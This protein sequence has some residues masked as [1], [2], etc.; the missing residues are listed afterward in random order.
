MDRAGRR[1]LLMIAGF[2]MAATTFMMS[3]YYY[4]LAHDAEY[5][6]SFMS[7]AV[8]SL[9]LYIVGYSLGWGPVPGLVMSE[10]FPI[11][12]RASASA[13]TTIV[14]WGS[15]FLMTKIFSDFDSPTQLSHA[16][17]IFGLALIMSVI[18]VSKLVPETKGKRL[19][20]IELYFL[21]V[22]EQYS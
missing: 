16:F 20:D 6:A 18:F 15:S 5:A 2:G 10:I 13:L 22:S 11:R 7:L 9:L 8:A 3:F 17:F 1:V 4:T 19:E 14:A 21:G 12:A